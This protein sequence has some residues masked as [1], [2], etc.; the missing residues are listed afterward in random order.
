MDGVYVVYPK[1]N[2]AQVWIFQDAVSATLR[3]AQQTGTDAAQR[4]MRTEFV[5]FGVDVREYL[6]LR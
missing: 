4:D 5:P 2:F 3:A 6:R 1:D